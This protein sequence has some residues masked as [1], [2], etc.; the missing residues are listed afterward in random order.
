MAPANAPPG[1]FLDAA[2]DMY[3]GE[4]ANQGWLASIWG[5]LSLLKLIPYLPHI[6]DRGVMPLVDKV[7][8]AK[9]AETLLPST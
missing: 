7:R 1:N 9:P 2:M 6:L 3:P 8:A 5:K 4:H